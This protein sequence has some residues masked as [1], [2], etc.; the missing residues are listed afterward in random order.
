MSCDGYVDPQTVDFDGAFGV[1]VNETRR[2]VTA[3]GTLTASG[4]S[5]GSSDLTLIG[6][7]GGA[8]NTPA[9]DALA[10]SMGFADSTDVVQGALDIVTWSLAREYA[11]TLEA[12]IESACSAP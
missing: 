12:E 8:C 6:T 4:T 11:S 5:L 2:S 7:D 3:E 9:L 1:S 10:M